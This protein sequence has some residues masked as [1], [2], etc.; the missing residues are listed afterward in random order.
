MATAICVKDGSATVDGFT[1]T[2]VSF[3]FTD[4]FS[5][6]QSGVTL[7]NL[8]LV[9]DDPLKSTV[10]AEDVN[11]FFFMTLRPFFRFQTVPSL[12][13][14]AIQL[15]MAGTVL[16]PLQGSVSGIPLFTI[17]RE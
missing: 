13:K 14:M 12:I 10:D 11:A 3:S 6:G 8:M 2:N 16:I 1:G 9:N 5:P 15:I 7:K 17:L 4:A